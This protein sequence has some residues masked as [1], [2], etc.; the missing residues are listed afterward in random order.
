MTAIQLQTRLATQPAPLLVHLLPEEVFAAARIPGSQNV[1][2]YE[3]AF[4]T[5]VGEL[6]PDKQRPIIIY[7]AGAGSQDAEVALAKLKS[8]GYAD[9]TA[10][11]G[12]LDAWLADGFLTEGTGLPL[13]VP[14]FEG[15]YRVDTEA[16]VIRW[17]GRNLFNHHNGTI[18]LSA[19]EIVL[20][21]QNLVAASFTVAMNSIACEDLAD[22]TWNKM[23]IDHLHSDDFFAVDHF[24]TAS[25]V[26]D[27]VQPLPGCTEGSPNYLLRG[28]FTLRGITRPVEFP[29][30]LATDGPRITAQGQLELDRTEFGSVYGSGKFFRFL[31]KHI[32]NDRIHLHVKLHAD[33][34]S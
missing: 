1:C 15:T 20:R 4:L 6:A 7:G 12:G 21:D 17:T 28:Q 16:S 9:V 32:V 33:K 11:E 31:G 13:K 19:G 34:Q 25:F 8:A 30:V 10:L 22:A 3:T 23:L 26:A 29:I 5:K 14:S 2:V 24:P 27:S 18:K